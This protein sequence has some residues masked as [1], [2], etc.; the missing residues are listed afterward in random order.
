MNIFIIHDSLKGNGQELAERLGSLL[1]ACGA[2]VEVGHRKELTPKQVVAKSPDLLIV[3]AAV[4][5]FVTSPPIKRWI[6][7]LQAELRSQN[8]KIPCA[9]VF[10]T[11]VMPDPMVGN[12]VGRLK[13][14]LMDVEGIGEVYSEWLSGQVKDIPGPFIDGVPEKAEVFA[15]GLFEWVQ[16]QS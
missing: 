15:N 16:S 13:Q 14:S 12:R 3:G 5:A 6:T 2:Q 8:R 10:L 1:T 7:R 4:R 11:H 9:A